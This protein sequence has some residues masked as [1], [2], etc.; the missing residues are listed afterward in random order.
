MLRR[1][2]VCLTLCDPTDCKPSRLL[3]PWNFPSRNTGVGCHFL[4]QG[5]LPTQGS[6]AHLLHCLVDSL[7][8]SHLGNPE[9]AGK[10]LSQIKWEAQSLS[11]PPLNHGFLDTHCTQEHKPYPEGCYLK[12]LLELHFPVILNNKQKTPWCGKSQTTKGA[13]SSWHNSNLE[14]MWRSNSYKHFFFSQTETAI[15]FH[16]S[17]F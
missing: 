17:T 12:P 10:P 8:L 3:C 1:S 9:P 5:I 16:S 6:N 7:P 4:L 11:S 14:I 15:V 2:V 13:H